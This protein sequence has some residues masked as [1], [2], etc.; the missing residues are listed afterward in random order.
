MALDQPLLMGACSLNFDATANGAAEAVQID[1]TLKDEDTV[2]ASETS[3]FG[4]Q[5]DQLAGNYIAQH[6]PG[7]EPA[8]FT[9]SVLLTPSELPNL[10][11]AYELHETSGAIGY[12]PMS[13]GVLYGELQIH[14]IVKG[15]DLTYDII[16]KKVSCSINSS[17]NFKSEDV[18]KVELMFNFSADDDETSPS[19]GM[20]YTFGEWTV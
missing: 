4:V 16:G 3:V 15:T 2:F 11:S 7:D 19:Y 1:I 10:C 5:V 8:T 6:I 17:V 20:V 12:S 9:C 13:K 18:G 14:P